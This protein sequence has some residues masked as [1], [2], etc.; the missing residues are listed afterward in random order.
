MKVVGVPN[1]T[2]QVYLEID[3]FGIGVSAEGEMTAPVK[4]NLTK[5]SMTMNKIKFG[6]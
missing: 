6:L 1:D 5:D 4:L 2:N 3:G